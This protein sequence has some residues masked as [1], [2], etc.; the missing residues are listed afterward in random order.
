MTEQDVWDAIAT[1]AF[2]VYTTAP[3]KAP[4]VG[5]IAI[6][7]TEEDGDSAAYFFEYARLHTFA[8]GEVAQIWRKV[9][10]SEFFAHP[11]Y[12]PVPSNLAFDPHL[13]FIEA[14][15]VS[16]ETIFDALVDNDDVKSAFAFAV[17]R[18]ERRSYRKWLSE[19]VDDEVYDRDNPVSR[20]DE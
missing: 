3:E 12:L 7:W 15:P 14:F 10:G 8:C 11:R 2:P 17:E 18:G 19:R 1:K 6:M 16:A 20:D 9:G 5:T 13:P 4:P